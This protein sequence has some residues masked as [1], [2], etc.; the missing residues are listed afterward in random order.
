MDMHPTEAQIV[1]LLED[2]LP[3]EER[4]RVQSHMADCPRCAETLAAVHRMPEVLAES[5]AP[6]VDPDVLKK[7]ERLVQAP[8]RPRSWLLLLPAPA[9]VGLAFLVVVGLGLGV[10]AYFRPASD[11]S[12]FRASE[13]AQ[14]LTTVAPAHRAVV[15]AGPAAF[16]W[17]AM[18]DAAAYRLILSNQD[19]TTRWTG[20]TEATHLTLPDS[21]MLQ[22]DRRYLWRVEAVFPD[23]TTTSSA[24]RTFT[25]A[26]QRSD[27]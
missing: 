18:P 8:D 20:H 19:G 14:T 24:I 16:Q 1:L 27:E 11:P 12:P 2:K 22:P 17:S 15:D 25:Y 23:G 6:R 4:Q 7:A 26:P 9:R 21:V 13:A 3:P 5:D 10:F